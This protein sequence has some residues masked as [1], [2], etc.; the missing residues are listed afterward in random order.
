MPAATAVLNDRQVAALLAGVAI[1]NHGTHRT[2][3]VFSDGKQWGAYGESV[4]VLFHPELRYI[5]ATYLQHYSGGSGPQQCKDF[6]AWVRRINE[7][8]GPSV[9]IDMTMF[10]DFMSDSC[11]SQVTMRRCL[12][13]AI[14]L[15]A[16][17]K[18]VRQLGLEQLQNMVD[19]YATDDR[20]CGGG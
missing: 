5:L 12:G 13:E 18:K 11:G 1:G 17:L 2:V 6:V 15:D 20:L 10:L 3:G 19:S 14:R 8:A 9:T 16:A 7:L 4:V